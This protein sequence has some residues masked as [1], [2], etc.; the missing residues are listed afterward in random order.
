MRVPGSDLAPEFPG[1]RE[2][3]SRVFITVPRRVRVPVRTD[4]FD[5]GEGGGAVFVADHI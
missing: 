3:V 1:R 5:A 4:L 2:A